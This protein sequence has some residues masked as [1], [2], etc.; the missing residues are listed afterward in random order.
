MLEVFS[1]PKTLSIRRDFA[2]NMN[3]LGANRKSLI[4]S[5][6]CDCVYQSQFWALYYPYFEAW[7]CLL[8]VYIRS[9]CSN[10]DVW[11]HNYTCIWYW[12]H[13][14]ALN[15]AK[16]VKSPDWFCLSHHVENRKAHLLGLTFQFHMARFIVNFASTLNALLI[17]PQII[18]LRYWLNRI[19]HSYCDMSA[20]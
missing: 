14:R 11:V 12:L 2:T 4:G 15:A 13:T 8:E 19:P 1:L 16:C 5:R 17:Y 9:T 7:Q 18:I 3:F 20:I 10:Y 6:A